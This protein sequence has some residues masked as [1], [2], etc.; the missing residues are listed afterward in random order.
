MADSH[1]VCGEP[2]AIGRC[3]RPPHGPDEEHHATMSP[4]APMRMI[5]ESAAKAKRSA[6][7]WRGFFIIATLAQVALFIHRLIEGVPQ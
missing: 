7:R 3:D 5:L 6:D 4:P 1:E 2:F